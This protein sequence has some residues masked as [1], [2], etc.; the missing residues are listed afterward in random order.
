MLP[1]SLLKSLLLCSSFPRSTFDLSQIIDGKKEVFVR[2]NSKSLKQDRAV[3]DEE[4]AMF[5][6]LH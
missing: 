2:L 5:W 3:F 1:N 4:Y 6:I